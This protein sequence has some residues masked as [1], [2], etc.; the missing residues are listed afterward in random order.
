M[1]LGAETGVGLTKGAPKFAIVMP[2]WRQAALADEAIASVVAQ[3]R[4]NWHLFIVNDGCPDPETGL[5]LNAWRNAYPTRIT[6]LTQGNKG[7]SAARNTAIDAAQRH[8][9]FDGYFMLDA[10]NL[11]DDDATILWENLIN[12][13]SAAGWFYPQFDMF[14]SGG[15]QSNGGAWSLARMAV[16]NICDAGSLVK[17][18]VLEAGLRFDE[19][20]T[21]GYEDWD[22]WLSA[23]RMG[24]TGQAIDTSFFR[25]RRRGGSMLSAAHERGAAL[26]HTIRA[27]HAW[28]FGSGLLGEIFE[29]EWPRFA[30]AQPNAQGAVIGAN[31][32]AEPQGFGQ[33]IDLWTMAQ[34]D[35]F[36]SRIPQNWVFG[37]TEVYTY[38]RDK[39][40]LA[41]VLLQM[42]DALAGAKAAILRF[43]TCPQINLRFGMRH[44]DRQ[45]E[46]LSTA[47]LIMVPKA[48]L[49]EA[50]AAPDLVAALTSFLHKVE[51][52]ALTFS[53]PDSPDIQ[54]TQ[55]VESAIALVGGL[56]EAHEA[57]IAAQALRPWRAPAEIV[58]PHD[59]PAQIRA[60]NLG[61][62][63]LPGASLE[64]L[65]IG[66]IVPIFKFGGVEKCVVALARALRAAGAVPQLFIYGN[67]AATAQNWMADPFETVHQVSRQ[68]LRDWSGAR[69][70]GTAD[71]RAPS[72]WISGPLLGP[73]AGLDAVINAGCGPLNHALGMLR[74][75]G[76]KTAVWEHLVDSTDY[77]R[78]NGTPYL[79]LSHEASCDLVLTCSN[80]LSFWLEGQGIARSKLLPLPN[81][82]GFPDERRHRAMRDGRL[83]LRVGFMGRLDRQ[84]GVDR[85]IEIAQALRGPDFE[86]SLVGEA[87]VEADGVNIPG[88][89]TRRAL[90]RT[91][92]ELS[93]A[94][95]QLDIL[96]MPSRAEGLPLAVLEAQRAGAVPVIS[97]VGAVDEAV[98]DGENG[99]L[100]APDAVVGDAI[101]ALRLLARDRDLL[102]RLATAPV[103]EDRWAE[104][105]RNLLAALGLAP[106]A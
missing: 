24:F 72:A 45:G 105:A 30:F 21:A 53:A 3:R 10:D 9:G 61:G 81:G 93:E 55:A 41:S 96:L 91:P 59:L 2:V 6:V 85:F 65:K 31:P 54:A 44:V 88:W 11:L 76:V 26:A 79:A 39:K 50:V 74:R 20:L 33:V 46:I 8:G 15:P 60:L 27:K 92:A 43:D 47:A 101:A 34:V 86:F 37:S 22:F 78:L 67:D 95:A 35:P 63:T 13:S 17:S 102:H 94:Y 14:G 82:P 66:F 28:L 90:A 62:L 48:H 38:L 7:L 80:A 104:N 84:K 75:F 71:G 100:L 52:S 83:P 73:L 51:V 16:S 103:P 12:S 19:S 36:T 25:Y 56:H 4:A 29:R 70:F 68:E 106:L 40:R 87:V 97:R 49:A 42:E 23:A 32:F 58:A 1:D 99:I 89:I 77:G 18:R 57:G 69:Y 64:G 5:A 98:K